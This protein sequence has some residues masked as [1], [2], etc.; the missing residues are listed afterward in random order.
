MVRLFWIEH[1]ILY[2]IC[3]C[4]LKHSLMLALSTHSVLAMVGYTC[5]GLTLSPASSVPTICDTGNEAVAEGIR[6]TPHH[7]MHLFTVW[8]E[9]ITD[10]QS[11]KQQTDM[12][13]WFPKA[14]RV[15]HCNINVTRMQAL[16]TGDRYKIYSTEKGLPC[17]AKCNTNKGEKGQGK[18]KIW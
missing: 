2:D 8:A 5:A 16:R 7:L 6:K 14:V 13:K 9:R 12:S 1:Y 11:I 15:Q 18:N 4:M 10:T 3:G 17:W